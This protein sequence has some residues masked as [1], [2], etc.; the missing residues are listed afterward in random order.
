MFNDIERTKKGDT[1][2]CFAHCQR[3]WQHLQ[4]NSSQDTGASWS[5]RQKILG[6]TQIPANFEE[7]E[8]T[9]Y[10]QRQNRYRLD[11]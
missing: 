3:K 5:P 8:I 11:K 4:P 1:E 7:N 10:L 2:T 9:R 6:G